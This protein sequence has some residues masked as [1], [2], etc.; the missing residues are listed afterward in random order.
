M[1]RLG[2]AIFI[3]SKIKNK[4]K[5]H[6]FKVID[7]PQSFSFMKAK[8]YNYPELSKTFDTKTEAREYI[9]KHIDSINKK[10]PRLHFLTRFIYE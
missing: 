5:Y 6:F 9:L 1:A 7:Y 8:E 2:K 10:Y 4:K 3:D